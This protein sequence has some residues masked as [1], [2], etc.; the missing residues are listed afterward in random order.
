VS[1]PDFSDFL[2]KISVKLELRAE[3]T[4]LLGIF[5]SDGSIV[6]HAKQGR[7]SIQKLENLLCNLLYKILTE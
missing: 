6:C 5:S 2:T 1:Q 4:L 7:E 3:A